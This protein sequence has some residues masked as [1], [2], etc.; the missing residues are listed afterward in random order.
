[1][2]IQRQRVKFLA[3]V[4]GVSFWCEDAYCID[5]DEALSNLKEIYK[6]GSEIE[7][8]LFQCY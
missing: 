4:D 8:Y 7:I 6:E 1:M 5:P 3:V 2:I